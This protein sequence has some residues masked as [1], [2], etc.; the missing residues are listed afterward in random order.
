MKL[1][2]PLVDHL[3]RQF[4]AL[5]RRV[6]EQPAVFFDGPGG[7]QTPQRVIEAVSHYLAH[8]NANHGGV[9]A[10]GRESDR[11]LAEAHR[12]LADFLGADDPATVVFGQ[13]MTS[14][15]FALSRSLARTWKPGDEIVVTR[16]DHD[17]NVS[18]WVLAARDAGATI[19]Y[20]SVRDED[21]TLNQ[22]ELRHL[23]NERTKLVAVGCASNATGT[24]NPVR[25]IADWAHQVG[26][27]IFLDA[28]HYAPHALLD[29]QAL[30]CDFLACSAYKFFGP[31][32][33]ILWGR[34]S[35]L[36][37]LDAYKVRPAPLT[38]PDKWMT[39]TQSHEAIAGA[40]AAVEYL[41]DL[42]RTL[43]ANDSLPRRAALREAYREIGLYERKLVAR[44]L[45]GL[46][47]MPAIKVWG[48]NTPERIEERVATVSFTHDRFTAPQMAEQLGRTG[49]FTWHGNYYALNLTESLGLEPDGMLR[50]GLLHYNTL[51]EVERF[52][53]ALHGLR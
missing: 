19:R 12:G 40:L 25:D 10:T 28:V 42:G 9:F 30:G 45:A 16:L 49:F 43:A 23:L 51:T 33:G 32:V 29:V 1:I 24:I 53:E 37:K 5:G 47:Q 18:P 8:T 3:R 13:N 6:N 7:T 48:I 35:L 26:A 11:L 34:R 21:C 20:A 46:D 52:L 14:L 41:A 36:E 27:L 50:V 17:A 22:D 2:P 31:H 15:T 44:L 38:L 39:G 4:P